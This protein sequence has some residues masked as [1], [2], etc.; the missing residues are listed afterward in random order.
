[1]VRAPDAESITWQWVYNL[2]CDDAK[3]E[4]GLSRLAELAAENLEVTQGQV[5]ELGEEIKKA[6][7]QI[8]RL[9]KF[10]GKT[11]DE[12]TAGELKAALD[13]WSHRRHSLV[14]ERE[15][16]LA[17]IHA[18]QLSGADKE[19]I[20]AAAKEITHKMEFPTYEQK[21][22]LFDAR[23]SGRITVEE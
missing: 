22:S 10:I 21:R 5:D 12:F 19:A 17:D 20:R 18:A 23:R 9:T 11:F 14:A 3:L 1:M 16:I 2:I 8:K 13:N 4:Q 15:T 7:V 6:E